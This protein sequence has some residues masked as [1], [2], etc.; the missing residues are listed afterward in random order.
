MIFYYKKEDF[1]LGCYLYELLV[2]MIFLLL[3]MCA[4]GETHI[5]FNSKYKYKAKHCIN[6]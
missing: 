5:I 6:K 4:V 3:E 1:T 2:S